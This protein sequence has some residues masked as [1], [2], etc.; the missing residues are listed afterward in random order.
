[1]TKIK[2]IIALATLVA[3]VALGTGSRAATIRDQA[4]LFRP[5][6][7]RKAQADLDRVERASGIPIVIETIDAIP[8]LEKDAPKAERE[9]EINR[10]AIR[11][12]REIHDEGLYILISKRD[13]V[14]SNVLIRQR[15]AAL[16]PASTRNSI[17]EAFVSEF[18]KDQNYDGGLTAGVQAIERS[19]SSVKATGHAPRRGAAAQSSMMGTFMLIILGILGVLVVV[20]LLGGLMGRGAGAGYPPPMG[21]GMGMPPGGMGQGAMGPGYGGGY[22]RGGGGGGFF[23][24]M[25]GGLGGALAGNWLYDQFS[26]RHGQM[27]T[28]DAYSPDS[29][30]PDTG[31]DAIVGGDDNGGQGESWDGGTADAGGGWGDSGGG[32]WG[33]GGGGGDWGGGGGDWGGGGGG[34]GDW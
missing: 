20:R 5:E 11:R 27:N 18:R 29:A 28:S 30:S 24:G 19:L 8:G 6:I 16:I 7:V 2:G 26:G 33:G 1:M 32:D 13:R 15:Y 12:D 31:G 17:R 22:G 4:G 3:S 21:G 25:L 14:I 10:E 34:G 23:S 9:T